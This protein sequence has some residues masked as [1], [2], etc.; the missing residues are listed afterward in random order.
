MAD[1]VTVELL[2]MEAAALSLA[3]AHSPECWWGQ[4]GPCLYPTGTIPPECTCGYFVHVMGG[5]AKLL[6]A[7]EARR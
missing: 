3:I 2:P 5:R 1:T 4:A 6:A 7:Y